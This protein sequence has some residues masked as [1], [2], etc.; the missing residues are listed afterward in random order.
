MKKITI[1][2][3]ALILLGITKVT[4]SQ[5]WIPIFNF[6][7][8]NGQITV[9]NDGKIFTYQGFNYMNESYEAMPQHF[10]ITRRIF[11]PYVKTTFRVQTCTSHK[12]YI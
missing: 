9:S 10:L 1:L 6:N 11:M 7:S 4:L 5:E 12:V 3:T 8:V 2:F